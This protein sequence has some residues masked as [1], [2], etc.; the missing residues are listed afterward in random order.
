MTA[1]ISPFLLLIF[2][3]FN[4]LKKRHQW[5][6]QQRIF[7]IVSISVCPS[8][9]HTFVRSENTAKTKSIYILLKKTK[10]K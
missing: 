4:V 2:V 9:A 1:D 10:K 6:L 7:N 8:L 3:F 5:I